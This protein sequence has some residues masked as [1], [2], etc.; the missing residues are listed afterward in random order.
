MSDAPVTPTNKPTSAPRPQ[1]STG[2]APR[3]F[4]GGGAPRSFSGG[5]APRSFSGPRTFTPGAGGG[6][7]GERGASYSKDREAR[8]FAGRRNTFASKTGAP[9]PGGSQS[10]PSRF[11]RSDS[12]GPK[13]SFRPQVEEIESRVIAVRRVTRVVKGGKRMKFSALVV[14]GD[15]MGKVGFG[16]RKGLDYQDAVAKALKKAKENTINIK[17]NEEGSIAFPTKFKFKA[18]MLYLKPAK[19][20]TGIIAGGFLRPVLE[21]CGVKNIYSKVIRSRNKVAGVEAA[22][23]ALKQYQL[24]TQI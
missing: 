24:E 19:T 9:T 15:R 10:G 1:S 2:G 20:G 6:A 23:E 5:G 12:R 14:V 16:L 17:L 21:L 22:F 4:G 7:G 13:K 11:Q 3:S 18:C 8:R